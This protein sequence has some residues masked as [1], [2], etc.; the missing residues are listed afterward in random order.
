MNCLTDHCLLTPATDTARTSLT[1]SP[2]S[3]EVYLVR[4][5]TFI[6][7]RFFFFFFFPPSGWFNVVHYLGMQPKVVSSNCRNRSI[8]IFNTTEEILVPLHLRPSE[9][10]NNKKGMQ[11]RGGLPTVKLIFVLNVNNPKQ[12]FFKNTSSGSPLWF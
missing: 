6:G 7:I 5:S 4:T 11:C 3:V 8:T 2:V 12:D 1:P 10:C 9:K